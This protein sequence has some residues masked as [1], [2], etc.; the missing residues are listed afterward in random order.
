M[1]RTDTGTNRGIIRRAFEDW[2][3]GTGSVADLFAPEMVWRIEGTSVAAKEYHGSQ[4]MI[5]EV[6]APFGARFS[7]G[8]PF[9]PTTIRS[10]TADGD[11]V[12][13]VWDGRGIANDGVAYLNS[14]AWIVRLVDGKIVDGTAFF[15]STAF[16]D[17]WSRVR[18]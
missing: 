14:Y 13:V 6:L 3:D 15:D 18:P 10:I 7:L 2:R 9:R 4:A 16:N 8:E 11:T 17:L 1:S 12:V 5:D